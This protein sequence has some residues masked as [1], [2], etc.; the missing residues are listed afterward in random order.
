V[1]SEIN[2]ANNNFIPLAYMW[3]LNILDLCVMLQSAGQSF[4]VLSPSIL[5][6]SAGQGK[7]SPQ[8]NH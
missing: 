7:T 1:E 3:E 4:D 6:R 5:P 8:V 2:V